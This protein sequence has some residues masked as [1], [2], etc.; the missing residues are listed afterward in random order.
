MMISLK[1]TFAA[2]GLLAALAGGLAGCA[3]IGP[4]DDPFTRSLT[5][6]RYVGGDDLARAC[7]AGQP[8]RYRLVYN[9]IEE[10]QRR[11]YDLSALPEGGAILDVRVIGRPNLNDAR[12]PI[13]LR[14][15]LAPWR[16]QQAMY[17]LSEAEFGQVRQAIAATGFEAP[18]PE[19]LFLRGDSFYWA[20]SACRDG[21][22]HFHAWGSPSAEFDRMAQPL[23]KALGPFDKTG[24]PV[25][26]PYAV[27]LPPYSS[28]FSSNS[29]DGQPPVPH[30]FQVHGNGLRYSQGTIN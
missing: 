25:I 30:R 21:Q 12:N 1:K 27:A 3:A 15:P 28:Y 13:S 26:Q 29:P 7:V 17:R 22:F 9:A 10:D 16:G 5:W 2:A 20:A 4:T 8:A 6:Q 23:L 11:T 24:V 14:D 19:G 18:A